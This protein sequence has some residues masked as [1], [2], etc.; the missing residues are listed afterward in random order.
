M[1]DSC[2]CCCVVSHVWLFVTPWTVAC[3]APLSMGF[4]RQEYWNGLLFPSPGGLLNPGIELASPAWQVDSLPLSHQ[5][6][7]SWYICQNPKNVQ[8]K[9]WAN[10]KLT[11]GL[12][13]ITMCQCRF[14]TVENVRLWCR[15]LIVGMLCMCRGEV[16]VNSSYC[17]LSFAVNPKLL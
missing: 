14:I 9:E 6:S 1:V 8:P 7:M 3:Q 4:P 11:Y 15:L 16:H 12:L 2:C 17:L 10:P 13:V 5:G